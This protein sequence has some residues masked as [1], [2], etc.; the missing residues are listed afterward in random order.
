[1]PEPGVLEPKPGLGRRAARGAATTAA[2]Q[3]AK[4]GLQITSVVV[5]AHLLSPTDFG[6]VAMVLAVTAVGEVLR[7]FGLSS[8]AI[9]APSITSKQRSNLFWMNLSIGGGLTCV[10]LIAA[11]LVADLYSRSELV[12][13]MQAL[14]GTFLLSG[15]STQFRAHLIRNLRFFPVMFA[16][17]ASMV[18]AIGA[19]IVLAIAGAG[20]WAIVTQQLVQAG[21]LL[22]V[23]AV[24]ARWLPG[25]PSRDAGMRELITFG[26]NLMGAQLLQYLS[27][28]VDSIVV[29]AQF[30]AAQLGYYNRASQLVTNSLNQI[31][32]PAS[33][34]A[35]PVLSRLNGQR[36]RWS[37]Y[38]LQGQ[39]IMLTAVIPVF[40]FCAAFSNE[41]VPTVLGSQ[42]EG[43]VNIFRLLA[44]AALFQAASYATYWVF[45]STGKTRSLLGY[46]L[47]TRVIAVALI[48]GA[49]FISADA[50]AFAF[51]LGT[52]CFWPLGLLWVKKIADAPSWQ[53]A[54]SGLK[55]IGIYGGAAAG[56][57]FAI[58]LLDFHG[59]AALAGGFAINLAVLAAAL[60]VS[61]SYR[62]DVRNLGK[63]LSLVRQRSDVPG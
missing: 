38:L 62:G 3:A 23:V 19:G 7:D 44:V 24:A 6:L 1:M 33:T 9:Q 20:Y 34:V 35:V 37:S 22:L 51:A 36:L 4:F 46:A 13:I 50:V 2:G 29:G 54:I 15:A 41:L 28:N 58:W 17:V 60:L 40:A 43:S 49:G 30:G 14:A 31:N 53:M 21:V 5:L 47:S 26:W 59:W 48:I 25:P 55:T 11:P 63:V 16:E 27:R 45:V 8:A 39:E 42:W 10:C 52:A 61:S 57:A 18:L 12:N 56:S 32:V